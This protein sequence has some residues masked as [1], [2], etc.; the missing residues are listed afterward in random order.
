M[1]AFRNTLLFFCITTLL[2]L[3][4]F[5]QNG[6]GFGP[7]PTGPPSFAGRKFLGEKLTFEGKVNKF[8]LKF[9]IADLSFTVGPGDTPNEISIR[10]D[11]TSKGTMLKLFRFSFEQ[12]YESLVD[13]ENFRIVKTIKRDVQKDRVRESEA[14]FDYTQKRVTYVEV[15]P[16]DANRPPRRIASEMSG[17]VNDMVSAIYALRLYPLKVGTKL[18]LKVS[19]SGLLYSIPVSVTKRERQEGPMGKV[20][21]LRVEPQIFGPGRLIE[22]KGSMILWVTEDDRHL[23]VR[24]T[25]DNEYGK[26]DIR[27][28]EIAMVPK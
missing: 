12:K 23:P 21:C 27:L 9:A 6:G 26:V 18:D 25:V 10:T 19:D 4:V 11:A 5:G 20:W 13:L 8:K 1:K 16:N 3:T 2:G 22:R 28:K 17:V 14:D 24:A 15:D 7:A